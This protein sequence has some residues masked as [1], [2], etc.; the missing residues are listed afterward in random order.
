[1]EAQS[2]LDHPGEAGGGE[3]AVAPCLEA[4]SCH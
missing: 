1:M 2:G 4:E 3:E